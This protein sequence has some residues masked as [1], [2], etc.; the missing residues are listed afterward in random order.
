MTAWAVSVAMAAPDSGAEPPTSRVD[1]DAEMVGRFVTLIQAHHGAGGFDRRRLDATVSLDADS[2]VSAVA[3]GVDL[4]VG[5]ARRCGLVGW[6]VTAV[7][8]VTEADQGE[9]LARPALPVLAGVSELMAILGVTQQRLDVLRRTP[10]FPAPLQTL[11]ATPVWDGA[12]IG[13]WLDN[14]DRRPGRRP[15]PPRPAAQG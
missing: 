1:A 9:R 10:G 8:A 15:R 13:R 12:V 2:A 4:V 14:W 11:A 6:V 7:E 5:A 3:L